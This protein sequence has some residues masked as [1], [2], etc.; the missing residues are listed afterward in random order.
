MSANIVS[1]VVSKNDI[2]FWRPFETHIYISLIGNNVTSQISW[3]FRRDNFKFDERMFVLWYHDFC[4][5]SRVSFEDTGVTLLL[6]YAEW[7]GDFTS[8]DKSILSNFELWRCS[9][10]WATYLYSYMYIMYIYNTRHSNTYIYAHAYICIFIELCIYVYIIYT[11]NYALTR[12][13]CTL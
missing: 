10:Q 7:N 2:R 5:L 11:S 3:V 12:K 6:K 8:I 13:F 4:A 1:D 9:S